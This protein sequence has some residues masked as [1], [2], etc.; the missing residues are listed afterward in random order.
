MLA[1][2]ADLPHVRAQQRDRLR[3]SKQAGFRSGQKQGVSFQALSKVLKSKAT[4]EYEDSTV[5]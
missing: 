3:S 2:G 4:Y 1:T 5:G